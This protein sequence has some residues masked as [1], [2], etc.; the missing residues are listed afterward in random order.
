MPWG[1]EPRE[2][3]LHPTACGG[4]ALLWAGFE[5][6]VLLPATCGGGVLLPDTCEGGGALLSDTCEGGA[7]L[8]DTCEGGVLLWAGFEGGALL[9]VTCGGGVQFADGCWMVLGVVGLGVPHI[10][11]NRLL[12]ARV[13]PT[14]NP[15]MT[16][17]RAM[18]IS[19]LT[20]R[21]P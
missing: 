10:C 13:H 18:S 14:M 7:L 5:G 9:W 19:C 2:Y 4:G 6:G 12:K 16:S 15:R 8:S 11:G 3:A 1:R 21:I 20:K 17:P